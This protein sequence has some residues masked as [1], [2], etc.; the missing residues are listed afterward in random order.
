[1]RKYKSRDEAMDQGSKQIVLF[2][3][4]KHKDR[5]PMRPGKTKRDKLVTKSWYNR[6]PNQQART[7]NLK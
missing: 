5:G 7:D 2:V 4:V 3:P 1:M 6:I